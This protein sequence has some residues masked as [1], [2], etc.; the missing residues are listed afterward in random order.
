MNSS[1]FENIRVQD[2][3]MK[4]QSKNSHRTWSIK[5]WFICCPTCIILS[6]LRVYK[7]FGD[8]CLTYSLC[9]RL[10]TK[11]CSEKA[12]LVMALLLEHLSGYLVT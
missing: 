5:L 11:L 1:R 10:E 8:K 9:F 12:S 4:S 2:K 6:I 3:C 7:T